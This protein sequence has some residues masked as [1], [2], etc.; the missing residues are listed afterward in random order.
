MIV[1][2]GGG[3][4]EGRGWGAE[5]EAFD[6]V[7]V[8]RGKTARVIEVSVGKNCCS[9]KRQC[10]AG[11]PQ[12]AVGEVVFVGGGELVVYGFGDGEGEAEGVAGEGADGL[13]AGA[14][15]GG[16][17][18]EPLVVAEHLDEADDVG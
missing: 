2:S 15:P 14:L 10:A 8:G 6:V 5:R 12:E 9:G 13:V 16:F 18:G 11:L 17:G 7:K 4:R 3:G 1:R